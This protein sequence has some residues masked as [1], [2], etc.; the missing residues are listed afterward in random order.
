[1]FRRQAKQINELIPQI[2]RNQGLETPLLQRRILE[3]WETVAGTIAAK[4]TKEKFIRNQTLFVKISN[5][6]LRQD[7]SMKKTQL[8]Q[9][10]NNAVK[11]YVIADVRIY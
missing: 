10:L 4:Y 3:S 11:A 1:M 7:L 5:P 2:L 6:A 9:M 8:A